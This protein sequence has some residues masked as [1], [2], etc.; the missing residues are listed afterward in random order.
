[1]YVNK[2][3]TNACLSD[4][5]LLLSVKYE[6]RAFEAMR[7]YYNYSF[8]KGYNRNLLIQMDHETPIQDFHVEFA[9]ILIIK[10]VFN[11][12][13]HLKYLLTQKEVKMVMTVFEG[14]VN[15][16][17]LALSKCIKA[18][19][20]RHFSLVSTNHCIAVS[21]EKDRKRREES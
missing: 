4:I 11:T 9:M 7:K 1:M 13:A 3:P 6:D 19:Q 12:N 20:V 18:A 16:Y 15:C 2:K 10:G 14:E 8:K 21:Y 17:R 5:P